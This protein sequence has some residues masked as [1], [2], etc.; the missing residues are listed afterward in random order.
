[1][2]NLNVENILLDSATRSKY[3][4]LYLARVVEEFVEVLINMSVHTG[5]YDSLER[6]IVFAKL[7]KHVVNEIL[8]FIVGN[9]CGLHFGF[10]G[11]WG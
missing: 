10:I 6:V 9:F 5:I 1:V 7:C 2:L 4:Y 3:C 8:Q 11:G